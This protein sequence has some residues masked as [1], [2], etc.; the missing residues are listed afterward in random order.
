MDAARRS[1]VRA[2]AAV[3][4]AVDRAKFGDAVDTADWCRK[5]LRDRHRVD[6]VA[7]LERR[8]TWLEDEGDTAAARAV[9]LPGNPKEDDARA[10]VV[11]KHRAAVAGTGL[12]AWDSAALVAACG[13]AVRAGL[14]DDAAVWPRLRMAGYRCQRAYGS[15]AA[16]AAGYEVGR[17]F[18][19]GGQ[20]H[21]A[22][23]QALA[24]LSGQPDSP[25][26]TLPWQLDLG[27]AG[28]RPQAR[29]R[30]AVCPSCGGVKSQ[31]SRTAYVYCDYCGEL[32]D[33]DFER[34][35]PAATA[36]DGWERASARH[37]AAMGQA[38]A[39]GDRAGY[40]AAQR[41]YWDAYVDALAASLSPRIADPAYR[42]AWCDYQADAT[43]A[44]AFDADG[45][46]LDAAL[47]AAMAGL[48]YVEVKG[49]PRI[50]AGS[51]AP[52]LDAFA[53]RRARATALYVDG[54]VHARHPDRISPE[55]SARIEAAH[56]VQTWL[57]YLDEDTLKATVARLGVA[58]DYAAAPSGRRA[59]VPCNRC[60][61]SLDV[62]HGARRVVC[63][64]CGHRIDLVTPAAR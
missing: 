20:G 13:W 47:A 45:Q 26:Q 64:H 22:S 60:G 37:T 51:F 35:P 52:V 63:E 49:K 16:F 14:I 34:S 55:V 24:A 8:L 54:G 27:L 18:A 58:A 61:V 25:W 10:S 32:C 56:F 12:V 5:A 19:S 29:Y 62:A 4:D 23:A 40:R 28:A 21:K 42:E 7:Q 50:V 11:R 57:P 48:T 44:W 2:L 39:A 36:G 6:S 17:L 41:R 38:Y 3:I 33:F 30:A 31:P 43:T 15:W 9:S 1:W 46:R 53:A 59:T